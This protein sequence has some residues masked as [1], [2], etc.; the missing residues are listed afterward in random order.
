V[1]LGRTSASGARRP[2]P[3]R[4]HPRLRVQKA[5]PFTIAAASREAASFSSPYL[6]TS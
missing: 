4:P 2:G 5:W 3:S 1:D 6:A